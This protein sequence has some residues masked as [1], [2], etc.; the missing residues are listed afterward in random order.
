[1][2]RFA[3]LSAVLLLASPALAQEQSQPPPEQAEEAPTA[4]EPEAPPTDSSQIELAREREKVRECEGEKFVFAWGA[5]ARP[6]KVTLCSEKGASKEAVIRML[7]DAAAKV[8]ASSIPED[9]RIALVQQIRAKAAELQG[10][11]PPAAAEAAPVL[12]TRPDVAALLSEPASA[13]PPPTTVP[14]ARPS[15]A[16]ARPA[17]V[18]A[19]ALAKPKLKLECISAEFRSGGP[20]ISLS[21]DTILIVRAADALA[22]GARLQFVRNGEIRSEQPLGQLRTGQSVRFSIP[23]ELCSG[24]SEAEVEI[25]V[26][27]GAQSPDRQGQYLLR[28]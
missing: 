20:C 10:K 17:T 11:A 27:R 25:R 8:E 13:P 5:G 2:T 1:M 22:P 6:T 24:V 4:A 14:A 23:R 7:E 9:R 16:S 19:A 28:C 12:K 15:A 26:A 21:R 18:P 3:L